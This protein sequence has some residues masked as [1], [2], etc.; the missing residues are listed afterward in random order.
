MLLCYRQFLYGLGWGGYVPTFWIQNLLQ[1]ENT[2]LNLV[3]SKHT[4]TVKKRPIKMGKKTRAVFPKIKPWQQQAMKM[5]KTSV[6]KSLQGTT[7]QSTKIVQQCFR[8]KDLFIDLKKHKGNI[9][10]A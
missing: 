2:E 8:K 10:L 6:Q 5:D 1:P 7:G 4:L 3:F 9:V